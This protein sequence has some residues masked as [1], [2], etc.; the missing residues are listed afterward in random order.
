MEDKER[1]KNRLDRLH[2]IGF[3]DRESSEELVDLLSEALTDTNL[4]TMK[5]E[6]LLE[7]LK[8]F[9]YDNI[10]SDFDVYLLNQYLYGT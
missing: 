7:Y 6:D 9:Q 1:L 10:V 5:D 3:A 8:R 4:E 2:Q